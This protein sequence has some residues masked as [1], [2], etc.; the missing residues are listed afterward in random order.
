MSH[1][2]GYQ[3]ISGRTQKTKLNGNF[4]N[5]KPISAGYPQGCVL[6]GLLFNLFINDTFKSISPNIEI[7]LYA[8]DTAFL[9]TADRED[10]LQKAIN[11][12]CDKYLKWCLDNCIVVNLTKSNFLLFNTANIIVR[13]NGHVLENPSCVKYL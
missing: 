4:S 1:L 8:D 3:T 2:N 6:S 11:N 7:N 12:F 10:S 13:L 5:L 9:I